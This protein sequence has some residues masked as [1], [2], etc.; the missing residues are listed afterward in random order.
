MSIRDDVTAFARSLD[1]VSAD[2]SCPATRAKYLDLIAPG[3]PRA[4]DLATLSGCALTIRGILRAV[5]VDHPLL[6][7][8][9]VIGHAMSD[10]LQLAT[11][12]GAA[13]TS[14]RDVE[15][16][17]IVVVGGGGSDGGGMEHTWMA[18]SIDD[19]D[20]FAHVDPCEVITGLDGGQRDAKG[21]QAIHVREHQLQRG[22]DSA[23]GS[24]TRLVRWVF[25]VEK[26][27]AKFGRA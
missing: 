11:A 2:P 26:I 22:H 14:R 4:A 13:Y 3:D 8:P 1:G 25:D 18:L 16:G 7:R 17:D 20:A 27:V 23:P 9:Y 10:L 19:C 6:S 15:P 21:F 5:G 12:A 24:A